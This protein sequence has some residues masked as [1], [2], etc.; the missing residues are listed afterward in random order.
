MVRRNRLRRRR[1]AKLLHAYQP[2][3]K[4][5]VLQASRRSLAGELHER[6][7]GD[8]PQGHRG[9]GLDGGGDPRVFSEGQEGCTGSVDYGLLSDVSRS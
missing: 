6:A 5:K 8:E 4:R 3:G 7:R 9:L 2:L 1:R